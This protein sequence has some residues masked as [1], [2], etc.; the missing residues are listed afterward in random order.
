MG[1]WA[2]CVRGREGW[3]GRDGGRD[4]YT[5]SCSSKLWKRS[6]D[7]TFWPAVVLHSSMRTHIVVCL[8][9]SMRTHALSTARSGPL[10]CFFTAT[11]EFLYMCPHTTICVLILH[12]SS[13]YYMCPREK[14][15]RNYVCPHTTMCPHTTIY[16]SSYYDICP[17]TIIYVLI[18]LH[19][20][21]N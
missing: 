13:Y 7:S 4:G 5:R 8:Y 20:S 2:A 3:R 17:H 11:G 15:V 18:L 12:V 14:K 10:F 19:V 9:S 21:S 1:G 16:V 6:L